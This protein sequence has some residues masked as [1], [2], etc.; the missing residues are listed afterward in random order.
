M[1][2]VSMT[3]SRP[4]AASERASRW[5]R[6]LTAGSMAFPNSTTRPC[7]PATSIRTVPMF[8]PEDLIIAPS[9]AIHAWALYGGQDPE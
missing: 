3:P 1:G 8:P 6:A 7:S 5:T 2:T 9:P 4:R